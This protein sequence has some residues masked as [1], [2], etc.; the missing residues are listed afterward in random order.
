M[1]TVLFSLIALFALNAQAADLAPE[2]EARIKDAVNESCNL[3]R[4]LSV[5]VESVTVE[6]QSVDQGVADYLYT[7]ILDV[8]STSL[9]DADE[10]LTDKIVVK[11]AEY[12]VSNPGVEKYKVLSVRSKICD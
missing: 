2:L 7:V 12:A 3:R 5:E 8:K 10:L 1:K 4:A 9:N 11:A 6:R